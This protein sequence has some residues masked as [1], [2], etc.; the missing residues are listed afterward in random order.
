MARKMNTY[1][2]IGFVE[3]FI[4]PNERG[5]SYLYVVAFARH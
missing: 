5:I 2:T 1:I 3:S 4:E